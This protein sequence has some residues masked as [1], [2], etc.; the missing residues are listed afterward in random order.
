MLLWGASTVSTQHGYSDGINSSQSEN[1]GWRE[2][3]D[4]LIQ[5]QVFTALSGGGPQNRWTVQAIVLKGGKRFA[6]TGLPVTG[7]AFLQDTG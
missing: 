6:L 5:P 4:Y 3:V 7:A 1:T 2:E